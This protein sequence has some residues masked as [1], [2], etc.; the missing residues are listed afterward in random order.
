MLPELERIVRHI[1]N[2]VF[3]SKL[4][5]DPENE[6]I[7]NHFLKEAEREYFGYKKS[8]DKRRYSGVF[9]EV[10]NN[11]ERVLTILYN[12]ILRC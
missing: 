11:I 7:K 4:A 5:E 9:R 3:L 6:E 12:E 10:L 2:S 8:K 1:E